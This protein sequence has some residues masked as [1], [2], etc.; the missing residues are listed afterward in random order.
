MDRSACFDQFTAG[1]ESSSFYDENL[2][3]DRYLEVRTR[4]TPYA[5]VEVFI[6]VYRK[7]GARI[8][9]EHHGDMDHANEDA[10]QKW[11]IQRGRGLAGV[12]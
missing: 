8:A 1:S 2:P 12:R 9:E 6:G 4:K 10:A 7:D 3:G 11:A 5:G